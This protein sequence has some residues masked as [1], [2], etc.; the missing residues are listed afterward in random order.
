[1]SAFAR[2]LLELAD[3]APKEAQGEVVDEL[4][5]EAVTLCTVHQ[6]KGLEWPIVVLP[7]LPTQ[8]RTE[9][10]AVRFDRSLG[11]SIV[12]PKGTSDLRSLSA[13]QISQQLTRRARAENLR[14][15]YVAMTR[16]RD[17][18]VLGLR[19]AEFAPQHLGERSRTPS[20][21]SRSPE[22]SPS[23][24]TSRSCPRAGPS[25]WPRSPAPAPR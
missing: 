16:A 6:A 12:R 10:A 9:N 2:E 24:S 15:L 14:L 13:T 7:D 18:L 4:D 21:P 22:S 25:P 17:R 19:P 8:P 3:D 1:M 20:S 11:L 5:L 23:A